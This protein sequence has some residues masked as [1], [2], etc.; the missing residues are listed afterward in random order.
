MPEGKQPDEQ[1]FWSHINSGPFQSGV[2]R[3]WWRLISVTWPAALIGVAAAP[4]SN[5]LDEYV[6][7]F[8]LNNYPQS[9]PTAVPW[10][11]DRD[12]VLERGKWPGGRTRLKEIF[13]SDFITGGSHHLY[14]PCDR[15]AISHHPEWK[16]IYPHLFWKSSSDI[17]LYLG[18][19]HGLLNSVDYTGPCGA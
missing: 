4:R 14:V 6:F 16:G 11:V 13:R 5:S 8:D 3:G 1:V 10:D 19:V 12:T 18:F 7:R 17:T 15:S 9:A 2:D